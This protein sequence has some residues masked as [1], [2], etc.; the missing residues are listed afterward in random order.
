MAEQLTIRDHFRES[1]I[2]TNRA[3]VALFV[4]GVLMVSLLV[5][6]VYLQIVN[7][8]HYATLSQ[9]NRVN[10]VSIPPIRG[11]IYD[12]NGVVLAE[13]LPTFS[14]E[15]IPE[16]IDNL[17]ETLKQLG[18]IV[19]ITPTDIKRFK[20]E[21]RKHRSFNSIPLR[22]R[23]SEE[24]VAKL[25]VNRYKFRGV[26]IASHLSR[27]Y[28]LGPL[29]VHALGYVGRISESDLQT[30]DSTNYRG[31]NHVGKVGVERNYE[32]TLHGTVGYEQIEANA[33]GRTLRVLERT[34]PKTGSNLYL[35]ID[36]RLQKVA[37]DAFDKENGALVAMDPNTGGI[38]AMVSM[39]TYDPNLFINGIDSD[40][41]AALSKS[42]DRPLFNR[43]IQGQYPPGSTVK[44]FIGLAGLEDGYADPNKPVF[45]AGWYISEG[46]DKRRY[47]DWKREGHGLTTL[48][49]AITESCD[50]YFYNLAYNMGIDDLSSFM[51]KF[52]FGSRTG[53]DIQGEMPGLM[54]TREW[55]KKVHHIRWF[56]G[57][58]ILTG[59]GQ[60]YTLATPIQLASAVAT[61][62]TNGHRV[63]PRLVGVVEDAANGDKQ[64]LEPQVLD[65]IELKDPSHWDYIKHAMFNVVHGAH[66]TARR[67]SWGLKYKMAGKT[68]TAQVFGIKEDEEYN[69]EE[70]EKRLHDHALFIAYAPADNPQIALAVIVENGGHA[71]ATAAPIARKVIDAFMQQQAGS[72]P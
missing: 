25:A 34:S 59:I 12:R 16:R 65:Q 10:L 30:L 58:T 68:G 6:L 15:L 36:T 39:P 63:K 61:M 22:F 2:F 43:A 1:H 42:H 50:V 26:E 7:H 17:D 32:D 18:E 46:E 23:L 28:P 53:V 13:N 45:C 31:S 5:R 40:Q 64:V 3:V 70:L 21:L 56:P 47:R 11:L 27:S 60:G 51:Q 55:K 54:P 20:K 41:Y 37:E 66:G 44:P 52:G 67:I 8:E 24:E 19:T 48:S 9:N 69:P 57:E 71:G 38:L 29:A 49:K 33:V 35:N 4:I 72:K 62:A 14:L